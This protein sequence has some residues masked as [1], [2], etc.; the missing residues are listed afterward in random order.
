MPIENEIRLSAIAEDFDLRDKWD[1]DLGPED[2][3][4]FGEFLTC[5]WAATESV[6][7][8]RLMRWRMRL[9]ERFGWDTL[10]ARPIPGCEESSVAARLT[11]TDHARNSVDESSPSPIPGQP[12]V[13][14]Y[15]FH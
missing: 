11:D 10:V 8:S 7:D 1:F 4:A 12:I 14:I 6:V 2:G 5:F 9:G 13:P 3:R 15:V